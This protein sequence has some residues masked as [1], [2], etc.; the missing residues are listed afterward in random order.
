[1]LSRMKSLAALRLAL[2][3]WCAA[4]PASPQ[5]PAQQPPAQQPPAQ[6]TPAQS[7]AAPEV[8][9]VDS[10]T[11]SGLD[12]RPIGPAVMGGR[13]AAM[14]AV[15]ES[16][17]LTVYVGSASG[18]V[19]KSTNGGTTFKPVF[20][21]HTQSVGAVTIDPSNPRTVWV[22]TGESWVR[23]SVSVGDGVYRS[24]DG[25]EN[26]T[27]L[28]LK[29]TERISRI[30]VHPR[31]PGTA[32]VCAT[33]HLWDANPERG[34]FKTADAGRTWRKVLSVND[35]TGCAMM[36][37][38]PRDPKTLYA[39]MW[40]FRR[41]PYTFT[42]GGPGSGLFKSTDG[43]ETWSKLSKGLPEGDLGR[44]GVAVAPSNPKT[45]YAVVEAKKSALFR[46][47]DA[48]ATWIELNNGPNIIGRPFYFAHLYVD[49]KD[50]RRVYKPGT[51]LSISEDGGKTFSQIAGSVHSDF[52]AMWIDPANP[53]RVLVGTDGGLYSSEDRGARW[54]FH[55]N[56]PVSQFYHVSYD[57]A[58]P[59]NVYG[60]LQDN[61]SWF[62]PSTA[63]GGVQNKHWRSVY[64]GDGFWVFE[65]PS[66]ADYVYAEYQ[67]GNL[68]RINRHTLETR[69]IKPLPRAGE[70]LRFNWNAPLHVSPTRKGTIYFG[71]QFLFRS[72]DRGDSWER[73]SPDL[74]TND[75][76][77]QR[78]EE[79]GGLTVDNSDA[80]AHT[81]IY[82]ISES[83]RNGQVVWA[84]TD[85]GNLQ[86][87][88]D[89]GR[90]WSNVAPNVPGL[91]RGTW[92]SSVAASG[93]DEAAAYATF[94][95]HA[96]GDMKTYVFKTSDFGKTWAPL[97]TTETDGYA[98]V[99][100]ED[101]VSRDLLFLGTETGLFVSVD[102]GKNWARFRGGEFPRV[103]VRD[104]AV[105]PREHDLIL[106]THGRGIWIVD[107]ITPLR[108]LTPDLLARDAAFVRSTDPVLTI[109]ASEFNFA[110]DAE[111]FGRPRSEQAQ[112]VYYQ[113]KRH[114][115]GDLKFEIYDA[116][117]Q[118][119]STIQ[120]N[121]RRGLNRVEWSMRMKAPKVPPAAALVPSFFSYVGP[122]VPAGEYTVKMIKNKDVLTTKLRLVPDARSPHTPED[123]A[124]QFATVMRLYRALGELTFNVDAVTGVRDQARERLAELAAGDAARPQLESLVRALEAI[125]ARLVA[126]R[127]G[128]GITGEEKIREKMGALYG[129]VNG[130]DGR[131]SQSQLARI[132]EL[133]KELAAVVTDFDALAK[134]E[135]AAANA[136]LA[137]K[138][139]PPIKPMTKADWENSQTGN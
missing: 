96:E 17:R 44:I 122:R 99:I 88:R 119:V 91:P 31:D 60:G 51:T 87:T 90:S 136:A 128:G 71:S 45:V 74:T 35:D 134:K 68:A 86:V 5:T 108:A 52:H 135:L 84:G 73:I 38:D 116:A 94:D 50:E 12:A 41:K 80:E 8:V 33:G 104:I 78:Q 118:L 93:F 46:S 9:K 126:T 30:V 19:W 26:W 79:S 97:A 103:A 4:L 85:D 137:A 53:E 138:N 63:V 24:T 2:A 112:I 47:D 23:N 111:F 22:G 13:I 48:G 7:P 61:S 21:K 121:K 29:E 25:G 20:D 132:D 1:M 114:I 28:G 110:G 113:K 10:D 67:G 43:G 76:A 56:L 133:G 92:V 54:R 124:L 11:I 83:P 72:R 55:A 69:D 36:D 95:G 66:D 89:G 115:F 130:Y 131:P 105:H 40:Q 32:Y 57:M 106:A 62:G 37:I 42:S 120:G 65:D 129:S 109:P 98:H 75:P 100:K 49:P 59:Y 58:R 14:D 117:G 27:H 34:V 15:A 6:T 77:K 127:E 102:G 70:K 16:N 123:R 81:T 3:V 101:A 125:R 139:L 107:D 64:G 18:G 82:T 39:A